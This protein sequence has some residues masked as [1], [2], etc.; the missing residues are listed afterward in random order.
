MN[1]TS[2][3]QRNHLGPGPCGLATGNLI[4]AANTARYSV[5]RQAWEERQIESDETTQA[6]DRCWWSSWPHLLVRREAK[7]PTAKAVR[8]PLPGRPYV[9]V[10]WPNGDYLAVEGD[11]AKPVLASK[12][13]CPS[14]IAKSSFPHDPD[15]PMKSSGS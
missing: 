1:R 2:P 9:Y 13:Q 12:L 10:I 3:V 15:Q 6:G 14:V 4:L 11:I 5:D 8:V 7:E